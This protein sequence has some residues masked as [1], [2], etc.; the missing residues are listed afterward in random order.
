V[1]SEASTFNNSSVA[2][3]AVGVAHAEKLRHDLLIRRNT[4]ATRLNTFSSELA[5]EVQAATEVG[6]LCVCVCV[7]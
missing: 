3:L 4:L 7:C 6:N 2:Q 5:V 1:V